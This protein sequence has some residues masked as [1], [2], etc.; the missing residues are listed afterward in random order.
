MR[1]VFNRLAKWNDAEADYKRV[2]IS[3]LP[4]EELQNLQKNSILMIYEINDEDTRI[5]F[6]SVSKTM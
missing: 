6:Q 2:F 3:I 5:Y 1:S 4:S